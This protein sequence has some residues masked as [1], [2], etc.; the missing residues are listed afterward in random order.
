ME[1]H[2]HMYVITLQYDFLWQAELGSPKDIHV[3]VLRSGE[4]VTLDNQRNSADVGKD[5]EMGD[6]PGLSGWVRC[7]HRGP[8]RGRQED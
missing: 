8:I 1:S 6:Y 3:Q 4:F 5:F 2:L 7:N